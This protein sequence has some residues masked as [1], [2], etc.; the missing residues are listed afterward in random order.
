MLISE[1]LLD[2]ERVCISAMQTVVEG[3]LV[4]PV[5]G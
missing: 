4:K 5:S 2:G 1:G 3:M